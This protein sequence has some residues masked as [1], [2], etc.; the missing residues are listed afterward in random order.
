MGL[1]HF[2]HTVLLVSFT[3][4]IFYELLENRKIKTPSNIFAAGTPSGKWRH[5]YVYFLLATIMWH[6]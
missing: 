4:I 3:G 5:N 1:L 2:W 6:A